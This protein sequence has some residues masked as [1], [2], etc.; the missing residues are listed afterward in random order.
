MRELQ[1]KEQDFSQKS[2]PVTRIPSSRPF[3]ETK[4]FATKS[5]SVNDQK[6]DGLKH[7]EI[8]GV[9][10]SK[11]AQIQ[12]SNLIALLQNQ[13]NLSVSQ[14]AKKLNITVNSQTSMLLNNLKQQLINALSSVQKSSGLDKFDPHSMIPNSLSTMQSVLS[15]SNSST[16]S[17]VPT[18][19]NTSSHPSS[20]GFAESVQG[21]SKSNSATYFDSSR[22]Q[23]TDYSTGPEHGIGKHAGVKVALAQLL[24]QQGIGVKLGGAQF[25]SVPPPFSPGS[26]PSVYSKPLDS[27]PFNSHSGQENS[28]LTDEKKSYKEDPVTG[29]HSQYYPPYRDNARNAAGTLN[30]EPIDRDYVGSSS[31]DSRHAW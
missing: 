11:D 28:N 7:N 3:A 16:L 4:P 18:N 30:Q 29:R 27:A 15:G 10:D 1:V 19:S 14:I 22:Q 26:D 17:N 21:S 13:Q 6:E 2:L 5:L 8:G 12:L 25:E 23:N 20:S 24:S 9:S 31:F